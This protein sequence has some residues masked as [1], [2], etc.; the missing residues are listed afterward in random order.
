MTFLI[1]DVGLINVKSSN[2]TQFQIGIVIY[3]RYYILIYKKQYLRLRFKIEFLHDLFEK[4]PAGDQKNDMIT[5][6]QVFYQ[7][8]IYYNRYSKQ[9]N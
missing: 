3:Y 1:A 6:A 8:M 2:S 9:Y 5:S 7:P 4:Y